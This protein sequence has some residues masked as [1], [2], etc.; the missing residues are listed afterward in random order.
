MEQYIQ[1]CFSR[2]NCM[3]FQIGFAKMVLFVLKFVIQSV[4]LTSQRALSFISQTTFLVVNNLLKWLNFCWT[5]LFTFK[6]YG[7][8]YDLHQSSELLYL[9]IS[10]KIL[11][12]SSADCVYLL[13]LF[14]NRCISRYLFAIISRKRGKCWEVLYSFAKCFGAYGDFYL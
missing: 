5:C 3:L 9:H 4:Q 1:F 14:C 11:V 2:N 6:D 7:R 13:F 10:S 8:I 12:Y